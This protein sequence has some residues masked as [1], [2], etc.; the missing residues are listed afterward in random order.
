MFVLKKVKPLFNMLITTMNTYEE[1]QMRGGII[2]S[3][4]QKGTLKEYQTV[5][6]VGDSVRNIKVG[7]VVSIN[8]KRYAQY[9]HKPGS[10][11]D[12][13][14]EDNIVVGYNFNTLEVDGKSVLVLYDQDINFIVEEF[15]EVES[16]APTSPLILPDNKIIT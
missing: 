4:K 2:D 1:D 5:L 14:I 11:K 8:P 12:G 10:L 3:S 15:E 13:V 7:D 6:S 16:P 9:K